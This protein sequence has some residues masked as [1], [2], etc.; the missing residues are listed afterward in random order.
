MVF[1]AFSGTSLA[2]MALAY[3]NERRTDGNSLTSVL[4]EIA[5]SLPSQVSA[6]WLNWIILRA[7]VILPLQYML[8]VNTFIFQWLG[9]KCCRRCVMGGGPG[10]PIPYRIYIDSGVVFMTIVALAPVSP[11]LAPFAMLY[12]LY[13]TPLWRRNVIY[14]YRPK[15]DTGGLRWPFL[16]DILISSLCVAQVLLTTVMSLKEAFGPAVLSALPLLPIIIHRRFNRKRYLRAYN[17]AALLQTSQLDGWDNSVPTSSEKRDEYRKFLVDAHKAAYVPICIAGGSTAALTA[18]P[19]LVVPH[20][21]DILTPMPLADTTSAELDSRGG[22]IQPIYSID[23]SPT[24]ASFPTPLGAVFQRAKNQ[25][26]AS[27]RRIRTFSQSEQNVA[28]FESFRFG[29]G[30]DNA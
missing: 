7:T 4:I 21:N 23:R 26:H 16:S 22:T 19:A 12:F 11:L 20:E 9:W 1:T 30:N 3:F 17:D 27:T 14:L 6:L 15:F 10:G 24:L 13:C 29:P 5:R 25:P 28:P 18:E 8:Q 2:N